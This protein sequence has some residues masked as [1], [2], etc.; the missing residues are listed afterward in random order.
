MINKPLKFLSIFVVLISSPISLKAVETV[1][2][3]DR[4]EPYSSMVADRGFFWV[5]QSRRNFNSDYRLEVYLPDGHLL[6]SVRL[7]HSLN[8][9]KK[10][11]PGAVVV[12]GINPVSHLTQYTFAKLENS[13]IRT[14]SHE[15][16]IEGFINFWV[17]SIGNRHYFA[18]MGGNPNDTNQNLDLP[19]QTIFSTTNSVPKYLEARVRM[20]LAGEVVDGKLVMISSEGMSLNAGSV[21]E[22]DP[23][24][25]Q[26][27][28]LL[29]S[30]TARYR[31]VESVSGTKNI[32]ILASGEN[33]LLLVNRANGEI[34][35]EFPT[36]GYSRVFNQIGHCA[37]VGNDV[38]NSI[39]VF[40][41]KSNENKAILTET[42]S[43]PAD[44]FS[45]I[46]QIATEESTG[47][48]FARSNFPCNPFI[49]V[50]NQDYNR[51][52]T[53]GPDVAKKV[54]TLC[55]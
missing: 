4:G 38:A 18:D 55:N 40:D 3:L 32:L 31:G 44:E 22:V 21:I 51:V 23:S 6:D 2:V 36:A 7:P 48:I 12:T 37:I 1:L 13:I 30:K 16:N 33:K 54:K 49:E 5:G 25:S 34:E 43:L 26:T 50:C 8:T 15:V 28:I 24:T 41:L 14:K 29:A 11:G 27:R 17:G 19:A 20:P 52:I 46:M 39:E 45:G 42:I 35:K 47:T 10:Q 9:I 53:F